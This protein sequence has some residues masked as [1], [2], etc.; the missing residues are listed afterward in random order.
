MKRLRDELGFPK[1]KS[2]DR[3]SF[4]FLILTIIFMVVVTTF[5]SFV[6]KRPTSN[7]MMG[8]GSLLFIL[9]AIIRMIG[10]HTLG[11]H[12][13]LR[14]LEQDGHELVKGGIYSVVRHPLYTG[15]MLMATGFVV[16]FNSSYGAITLLLLAFAGLYRIKVEE[17]FLLWKF[18][19]DYEKYR[20]RVKGL[21]PYIL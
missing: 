4:I 19:K 8:L 14:V 12:Y 17:T 9:G 21:I 2:F 5:D 11:R 13:S 16:F 10:S 20:E 18:G 3:H 7:F 15:G 6:V 1:G